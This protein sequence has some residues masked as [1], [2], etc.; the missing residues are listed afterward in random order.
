MRLTIA[1]WSEA[2]KFFFHFLH[3]SRGT[4]ESLDNEVTV[5]WLEAL[6][7]Y[8][9]EVISSSS[10]FL[11]RMQER[12]PER[13][14]EM[15]QWLRKLC[16]ITKNGKQVIS[17]SLTNITEFIVNDPDGW[18][19]LARVGE[20]LEKSTPWVFR[21]NMWFIKKL[22][23]APERYEY[24]LSEIRDRAERLKWWN[25]WY[26]LTKWLS[27][28][29]PLFDEWEEKF[30]EAMAKLENIIN[31]ELEVPDNTWA[32]FFSD[33]L[34]FLK[35]YKFRFPDRWEEMAKRIAK[36]ISKHRNLKD[37]D[38][39]SFFRQYLQ[40][41][42][43]YIPHKLLDQ[44]PEILHDFYDFLEQIASHKDRMKLIQGMNLTLRKN[45]AFFKKHENTLSYAFAYLLRY[46]KGKIIPFIRL[47]QHIDDFDFSMNLDVL[48][49]GGVSLESL[50]D[51]TL[52]DIFTGETVEDT[53]FW[54]YFVKI[55]WKSHK[56]APEMRPQVSSIIRRK[57]KAFS[58]EK[59]LPVLRKM[60]NIFAELIFENFEKGVKRKIRSKVLSSPLDKLKEEDYSWP[61]SEIFWE[62]IDAY[63]DGLPII[64]S[65]ERKDNIK[66]VND[67]QITALKKMWY[68]QFLDF[69]PEQ[70]TLVLYF[71]GENM[72]R[73]HFLLIT[74]IVS[75]FIEWGLSHIFDRVLI[76]SRW[77]YDYPSQVHNLWK[78]EYQY[79]DFKRITNI[80]A[81]TMHL[82]HGTVIEEDFMNT[83]VHIIWLA[84]LSD[85]NDSKWV[86]VPISW[87][88]IPLYLKYWNMHWER[89]WNTDTLD[90][91]K[92]FNMLI[93][94]VIWAIRKCEEKLLALSKG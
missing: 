71:R 60:Q 30:F 88:Y 38:G 40:W 89:I 39:F 12:F 53:K 37:G 55:W 45:P 21:E 5:A 57:W 35:Y 86:R 4:L 80:F 13:F 54:K 31:N 36:L 94:E 87:N 58:K 69:N 18:D 52:T 68:P 10:G 14:V 33:W 15:C 61:I 50:S 6:W 56:W 17:Q 66:K 51:T 85:S 22:R 42:D 73:F 70:R 3:T 23:W 72:N 79:S 62:K 91:S 25:K 93:W 77:E 76:T 49:F 81:S 11:N 65:D 67:A 7:P 46:K 41:F 92:N 43:Q 74:H 26:M 29:S 44:D 32:T 84:N 34:D 48:L 82:T 28:L 78:V 63:M 8:M 24:I 64:P 16:D 2:S 59:I 9:V 19:V 47:L 27:F 20:L 90:Q 83:T 75:K 1:C